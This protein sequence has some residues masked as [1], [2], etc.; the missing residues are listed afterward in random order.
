MSKLQ[1]PP[2]QQRPL[3]DFDRKGQAR[4]TFLVGSAAVLGGFAYWSFRQSSIAAAAS[5]V[6]LPATVT[7]VDFGADGKPRGKIT[8]PT[9]SK[10]DAEWKH[11]LS[12]ISYDV[13]RHDDTERP[14]TGN[15][16]D[17]HDHGLFRCICCDT[18]L[19]SVSVRCWPRV[20][21]GFERR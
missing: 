17:I 20:H 6:P 2:D 7:V 13:T 18:A 9:V 15:S 21:G 12:S 11:D 4:R 5:D 8:V 3:I 16:W 19:F 1:K 10:P 14:Y